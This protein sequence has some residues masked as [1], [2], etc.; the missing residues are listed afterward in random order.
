MEK[1][2]KRN[3]NKQQRSPCLLCVFVYVEAPVIC[4]CLFQWLYSFSFCCTVSQLLRVGWWSYKLNCGFVY[5]SFQ[6]YQVLLHVFGSS[7]SWCGL[8]QNYVSLVGWSFYHCVM[9]L[10]GRKRQPTSVFLLGN[11]HGWRS[12][13]GYGSCGC[14]RVRHNLATKQQ[15]QMF[16]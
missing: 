4:M 5:F 8:T 3:Q 10:W 16:L 14:R 6:L 7:D 1:S 12:L 15:K 2:E 9:F 13:A 11:P